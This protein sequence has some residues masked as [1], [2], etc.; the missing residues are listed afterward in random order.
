[1][2]SYIQSLGRGLRSC[3]SVGKEYVTI[4]DHG[5]N[6]HRH[7]SIN[8]DREWCLEDTD[9]IVTEAR[10]AEMRKKATVEPICCP[11]CFAV[12]ASGPICPKCKFS[13]AGRTR[14]V[15]QHD[16]T[17]R[18]MKGDIYKAPRI[19]K[20]DDAAERWKKYYFRA[21]NSEMTFNQARGLYQYENK[22]L[23]PAEGL[24]LMPR[25]PKDWFR[26]VKDVP[27]DRLIQKS[28]YADSAR[29]KAEAVSSAL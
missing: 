15:V 26:M 11:K 28:Q 23:A 4:Q 9:Y 6:W 1:M 29:E 14:M 22:W 18:E 16:G 27:M 8:S 21:C 13:F 12:R 25:E 3:P 19:D 24:P 10:E 2:T 7:G 20:R 5:G 17:L